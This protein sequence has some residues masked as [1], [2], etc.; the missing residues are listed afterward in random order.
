LCRRFGSSHDTPWT[1]N[2]QRRFLYRK[3][4]TRGTVF[5]VAERSPPFAAPGG[6]FEPPGWRKNL[7][8]DTLGLE[9]LQ[10]LE[11][12]QNR[13]RNVWKSLDENTLDLE[14]LGKKLGP[15]AGEVLRAVGNAAQPNRLAWM[16]LRTTG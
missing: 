7:E 11:I 14:R 13:Q 9:P 10:P 1:L 15:A 4:E 5:R 8:M 16:W 6:L 12:P 3:T 2:E